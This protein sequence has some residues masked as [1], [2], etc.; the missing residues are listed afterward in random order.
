MGCL[1]KNLGDKEK[2]KTNGLE[3][4]PI[5]PVRIKDP[6]TVSTCGLHFSVPMGY[7][8]LKLF[9]NSTLSSPFFL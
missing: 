9:Q 2:P 1:E 4:N 5:G 8:E 3:F 7:K 6:K